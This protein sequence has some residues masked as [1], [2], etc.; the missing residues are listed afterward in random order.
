MPKFDNDD[1]GYLSWRNENPNSFIVNIAEGEPAGTCLHRV[2]C[3]KL[4][5]LIRK[6]RHL[7]KYPKACF[8]SEADARR[9]LAKHRGAAFPSSDAGKG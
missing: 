2:T 5:V 3:R 4:E 8:T 1:A 9:L 6:G 7:T